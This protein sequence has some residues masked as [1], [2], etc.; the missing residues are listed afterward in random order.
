MA[1]R[2]GRGRRTK[3]SARLDALLR[4]MAR[5]CCITAVA[6]GRRFV[7]FAEGRQ[8]AGLGERGIELAMFAM[9]PVTVL[10]DEFLDAADAFLNCS[11]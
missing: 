3:A 1:S 4:V 7:G 8:A 9:T 6:A 5:L 11:R 2:L 10:P